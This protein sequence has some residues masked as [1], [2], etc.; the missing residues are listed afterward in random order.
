[1][2]EDVTRKEEEESENQGN[3][4]EAA[5]KAKAASQAAADELRVALETKIE[6]GKAGFGNL[7]VSDD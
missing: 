6:Q 3:Q 2:D 1:M 4:S 7:P 5:R